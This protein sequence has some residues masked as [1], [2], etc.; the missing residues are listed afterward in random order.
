MRRFSAVIRHRAAGFG[1]NAMGAWSVPPERVDRFGVIA[2]AFAAVTHCYV[3]PTYED[4]PFN[5]F[6]MVHGRQ[7]ADCE[8]VLAEIS[9]ETGVRGFRTL[10][11]TREYKKVRIRYFTPEILDWESEQMT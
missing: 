4:W 5:L 1:A 11:S 6:T 7:A 8:A 10:Y 3:R 9:E 2:A